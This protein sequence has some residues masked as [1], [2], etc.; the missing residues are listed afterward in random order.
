MLRIK[1]RKHRKRHHCNY[2]SL[3][4]AK[5]LVAEIE[6]LHAGHL[7]IVQKFL[8]EAFTE[9]KMCGEEKDS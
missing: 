3:A 6:C 5:R 1:H 8:I 7:A 2:D 4:H 9:G